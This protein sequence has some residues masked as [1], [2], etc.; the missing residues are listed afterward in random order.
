MATGA[1]SAHPDD[2][3]NAAKFTR[4]KTRPG[5]ISWKERIRM[6]EKEF[7]KLIEYCTEKHYDFDQGL[8]NLAMERLKEIREAEAA[9]LFDK[10]LSEL[11]RRREIESPNS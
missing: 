11:Q 6:S 3:F 9:E 4:L 7:D 10:R 5:V 1:T 8:V 2:R